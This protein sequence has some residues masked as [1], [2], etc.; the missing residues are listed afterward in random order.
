LAFAPDGNL[1]VAG[2]GKG[3]V[4]SWE[5]SSGQ[6]AHTFKVAG[7]SPRSIA[8]DRL[9]NSIGISRDGAT[10]A[11][12]NSSVNMQFP[13]FVKIWDL[14][15]G[16]LRRDFAAEKI[17]GRPM[18]LS[19]DGSMVATGGKTVRLWDVQTGKLLR[20]LVGYLKRTQSIAFSPDGRLVIAGGSYGT[21]NLWDV[22]TGKH[23]AILF[24]FTVNR[25]ERIADDWLCYT[26][27]GFYECSPDA[28]KYVAWRVADE[29]VSSDAAR[30]ELNQPEQVSAA[31]ANLSEA[32]AS[33]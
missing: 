33:K 15:T 20:E 5:I 17:A 2:D 22:K 8:N 3:S 12:C 27:A 30:T 28:Q 1:L 11:T 23:L 25:E 9:M 26:P 21:I 6:T 18:A 7:G 16:A 29:F 14:R 4:Y 19:P 13:E 24:A 10:L 31:L 32:G